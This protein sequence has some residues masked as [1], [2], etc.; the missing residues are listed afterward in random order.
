MHNL[1]YKVN[2]VGDYYSI[3][4]TAVSILKGL[5]FKNTEV[6]LGAI[7]FIPSLFL[8]FVAYMILDIILKKYKELFSVVI[9]IY[10]LHYING[11]SYIEK[12]IEITFV[13]QFFLQLGY[14]F[15]NFENKISINNIG[16]IISLIIF[17]FIGEK[18]DRIDIASREYSKIYLFLP[19]TI[20]GIYLSV[21]C[22]EKINRIKSISFIFDFIGQKS[23]F[24][25]IFHIIGY[26]VLSYLYLK[27][28]GL[29]MKRLIEFPILTDSNFP[30]L[31]T[32]FGV[33]IPIVIYQI[34]FILKNKII[35]LF[36]SK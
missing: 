33:V 10:A 28:N 22:S 3:K 21:Y 19:I 32:I 26:K 35:I 20:S 18:I 25:M 30:Y 2:F 16:A 36:K 23:Y 14:C 12:V 8:A 4:V 29:D 15:K 24:I 9:L 7:W 1:F 27:K 17:V 13:S 31:Y 34:F 6:L 5:F 11:N